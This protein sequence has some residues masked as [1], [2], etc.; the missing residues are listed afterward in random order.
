[1]YERRVFD[2]GCAAQNIMI[3]AQAVGLVTIP[4]AS[5]RYHALETVIKE[6]HISDD[7]VFYVSIAVGYKDSNI[8]ADYT[9]VV[10]T[11]GSRRNDNV[12]FFYV[13][14]LLYSH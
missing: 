7:E 14:L 3:A 12:M 1:L 9:S 11:F 2:L 4:V 8:I 6:L 13:I 5:P 10:P